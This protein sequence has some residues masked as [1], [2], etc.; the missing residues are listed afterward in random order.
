MTIRR[1][2]T[3]N[4]NKRESL[5][6]LAIIDID[7]DDKYAKA[8]R[9]GM[10]TTFGPS[11]Q[12]QTK[13]VIVSGKDGIGKFASKTGNA[14]LFAVTP[15]LMIDHEESEREHRKKMIILKAKTARAM[16]QLEATKRK[17]ARARRRRRRER[18][19]SRARE[20]SR[21]F[22]AEIEERQK[23]GDLP[24]FLVLVHSA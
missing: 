16:K 8:R 23:E 10:A 24:V 22:M 4:V 6:H 20:M 19:M 18:K 13:A 7:N 21:V 17:I 15:Q 12:S 14:L 9:Q 1:R 3:I 2:N 5:P 11:F